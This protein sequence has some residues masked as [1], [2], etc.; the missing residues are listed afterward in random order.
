M[1]SYVKLVLLVIQL[2]MRYTAS[3]PIKEQEDKRNEIKKL[4]AEGDL[5]NVSGRL[6][7]LYDAVKRMPNSQK[8]KRSGN[9]KGQQDNSSTP[10]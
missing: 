1:S 9:S 3:D 6:S 10:D 7:D 8:S 5:I 4:W 2:F